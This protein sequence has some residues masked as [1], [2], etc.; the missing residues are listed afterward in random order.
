MDTDSS[1]GEQEP[2]YRMSLALERTY[3]A[4]LRTGLALLAAGVAVAGALP[5]AGAPGLRRALGLALVL[6]G[7]TVL[8]AA[9][10]RWAAVDR[11]MR[12][13]EPMPVTR[14]TRSLGWLLVAAAVAAGVIVLLV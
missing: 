9:R 10:P 3:L 2:D 6:V 8:A 5:D 12:R 1:H 11:A 14:V 4:Y 7:G 13:G